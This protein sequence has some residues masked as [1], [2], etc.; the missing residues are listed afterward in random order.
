MSEIERLSEQ[1]GQLE[2]SMAGMAAQASTLDGEMRRMGET[3]V[4]SSREVGQL[5]GGIGGGLRRAFEGLAFEGKSLSDTLGQVAKSM[6]DSVYSVAMRPVQKAVGGTVAEGLN[7]LMSSIMPFAD[8]AAFSVGRVMPFA[9][10]GVVTQATAFPMRGG[11][12]LM[13]EAGPE[14]IMPLTR[15]ADGRLGVAASGGGRAVNVVMNIS[16]PDVEGFRRSQSQLAQQMGRALS[17]G[18]RNG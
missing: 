17:R 4:F 11:T 9:Q 5:A 8:G 6:V 13:G 15:G 7:G 18:Q 1:L 16:T 12:G 14:A 2:A 3:M 10:G